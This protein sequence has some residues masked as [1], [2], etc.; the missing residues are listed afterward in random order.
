MKDSIQSMQRELKASRLRMLELEKK[1]AELPADSGSEIL[2]LYGN[3]LAKEKKFQSRMK[4]A[5][6][7][8]P[9]KKV[10]KFRIILA[11]LLLI[12]FVYWLVLMLVF[13]I[14]QPLALEV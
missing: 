14:L 1:L 9:P 12:Y 7:R 6:A 5:I 10:P 13:V 2:T 8:P 3:L 11:A 4:L